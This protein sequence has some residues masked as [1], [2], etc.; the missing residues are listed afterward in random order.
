MKCNLID[1]KICFTAQL[2]LGSAAVLWTK[3]RVLLNDSNLF[4]SYQC[5]LY[6]QQQNVL[7]IFKY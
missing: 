7:F 3:K 5:V 6:S 2:R 4:F 1:Y